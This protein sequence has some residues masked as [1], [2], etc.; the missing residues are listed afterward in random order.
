MS[1]ERRT[2]LRGAFGLPMLAGAISV[3]AASARAMAQEEAAEPAADT[4]TDPSIQQLPETMPL[5]ALRPGDYIWQPELQPTGPVSIIISLPEQ[6]VHVYRNG[7]RIAVSTCSTGKAGYET[8]TG[9]FVVLQKHKDHYSNL[10]DNAPMPNMQRLTWGGVA[11]HAGNLPG[12]PASHGCVRL[13]REFSE[14]L[15]DVTH[16][17]TP[18]IV[19]GAH[20]DPFELTHPGMVLSGYGESMMESEL[21]G[22]E[23][24]R[25]PDDWVNAET[26]KVTTLVISSSGYEANLMENSEIIGSTTFDY[27]SGGKFGSHVLVLTGIDR[28]TGGL[29]W[30]T[31]AHTQGWEEEVATSRDILKGIRVEQATLDRLKAKMHPGMIVILTD[32]PLHPDQTTEDFVIMT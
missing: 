5:D 10:Y 18:I 15:F 17:G 24:N 9:T 29:T 13:P 26:N 1:M 21:A 6:L 11:L 30:T 2:L 8:P 28:E 31:I 19:S 16:M 23:Q 20:G 25:R 32:A 7:V 12:Y 4:A 27:P 14:K 22:I 3:S